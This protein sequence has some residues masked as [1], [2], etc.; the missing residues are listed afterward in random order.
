MASTVWELK[1][2]GHCFALLPFLL[3]P[4]SRSPLRVCC[5]LSCPVPAFQPRAVLWLPSSQAGWVFG[6]FLAKADLLQDQHPQ[7]SSALWEVSSV[8]SVGLEAELGVSGRPLFCLW[9]F[10]FKFSSA[11]FRAETPVSARICNFVAVQSGVGAGSCLPWHFFSELHCVQSG[12][13]GSDT[14][15]DPC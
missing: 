5:S 15:Q 14:P 13:L 7:S 2:L 4:W 8:I 11:E 1:L 3:Q 10:L 12:L 9:I 6:W